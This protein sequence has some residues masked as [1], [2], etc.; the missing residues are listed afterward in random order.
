MNSLAEVLAK[1]GLLKKDLDYNLLRTVMVI[2]FA[3]F[4]YDKWFQSEITALAP[5]ISHG[6][7]IFWTIPVLGIH[8]TAILLGA[9]EW[10]FGSL[11][12]L[13]F[14]NKK[15]G[16]L[17]AIGSIATFISTLTILPFVPDGW[18]VGAGGFPAMAM[19]A[20][21]LLKDLVLLAVSVY[22]LKQDTERVLATNA[23]TFKQTAH[24]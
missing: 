23:T 17:G 9:A 5:L 15:L 12:F 13:G 19:N 3:W 8:G 10:T 21:F 24:V 11:I 14:W 16:M 4:G 18:D 6:P 1:S 20:A 2:I 7:F 22:L